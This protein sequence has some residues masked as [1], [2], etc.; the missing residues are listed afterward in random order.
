MT[1]TF[2][3]ALLR[4]AVAAVCLLVVACLLV[5]GFLLAMGQIQDASRWSAEMAAEATAQVVAP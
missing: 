5:G 1:A 2:W 3:P 4:N